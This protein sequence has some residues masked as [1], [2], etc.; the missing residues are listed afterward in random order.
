MTKILNQIIF[1]SSTNKTD[2]HDI[3]EILLKVML[4]IITLT[5]VRGGLLYCIDEIKADFIGNFLW[6]WS[7]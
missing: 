7:K 5:H 3:A 4:Y 1:F 6:A 2:H